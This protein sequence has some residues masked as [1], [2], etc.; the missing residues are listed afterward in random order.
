MDIPRL[1][2]MRHAKSDW[3]D[4]GLDDHKRPLNRRGR[5]DAP[6]MADWVGQLGDLPDRIL[7]STATRARQTVDALVDRWDPSVD[8]IHTDELY[9][10]SPAGILGVIADSAGDAETLMVVGHN[11]G[12][13][14]L[15]SLL[16]GRPL[17]MPTAAIAVYS[18]SA[19]TWDQIRDG[20]DVRCIGWMKPKAL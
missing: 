20:G 14:T 3:S 5:H 12:M 7:C 10:A 4:A 17:E 15:A 9:L 6:R 1:L 18:R 11:P 2:L 19:S 16:A 8:V 13:A